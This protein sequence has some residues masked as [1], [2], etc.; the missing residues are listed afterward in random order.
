MLKKDILISETESVK[1]AL[2]KLCI[3]SEKVLLVI[4]KE[5]KLLGTI[6]DGDIRRYILRGKSLENDI[7]EVYNKEPIYFKKSDFSIELA[8]KALL[9]NRIELIPVLDE[10]HKVM[11][12]VIW[13]QAFSKDKIETLQA[14]KL[15]IPV[16][17]MAGGKGFRLDPFTRILP[18]P[19][20]PIGDKPIVEI[21]IEGFRKWGISEYYLTLNHKGGMI[22]A[23]FE[24]V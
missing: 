24:N 14:G 5:K 22:K 20:I 12:L 13:D 3:S 21:I 7:R 18:K 17:I 2:K 19:L 1:D 4:D 9:D 15:D 10:E 6:T 16:V 23:Y 8:K 11:D